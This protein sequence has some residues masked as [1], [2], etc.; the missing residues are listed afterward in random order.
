[1]PHAWL[2]DPVARTLEI[3]HLEAGRSVIVCSHAGQEMVRAEPFTAVELS[4][5]GL[6]VD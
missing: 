6:W 5:S 2:V 4:L 1:V 3:L